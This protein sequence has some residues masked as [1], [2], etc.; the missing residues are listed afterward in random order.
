METTNI[1]RSAMV[2]FTHCADYKISPVEYMYLSIIRSSYGLSP[3]GKECL[4]TNKEL[5][6]TL[7]MSVRT[8]QNMTE[9]LYKQG[10]LFRG[11]GLRSKVIN[12]AMS[13][14]FASI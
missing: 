11:S 9:K 4:A 2:D 5:A 13:E 10:Y 12:P 1:A 8:V 14:I 7:Q 3:S 6:D